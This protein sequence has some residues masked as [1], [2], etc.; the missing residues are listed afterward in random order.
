[1]Y[2]AGLNTSSMTIKPKYKAECEVSCNRLTKREKI[3]G[4]INSIK[5]NT[6]ITNSFGL[7][8]KARPMIET[9]TPMNKQNPFRLVLP[10]RLKV[11]LIAS[12]KALFSALTIRMMVIW[13]W[14]DALK[15]FIEKPN[16]EQWNPTPCAI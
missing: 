13:N 16:E 12:T 2:E 9:N 11:F 5:Q 15:P 7:I 3:T 1:M 10:R 6:N 4:E 8:M 14:M